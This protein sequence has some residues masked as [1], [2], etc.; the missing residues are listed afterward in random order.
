MAHQGEDIKF[1]LQGNNQINLDNSKFAV[2]IYF[3]CKCDSATAVTIK[4]T[5]TKDNAN[6]EGY[7]EQIKT[8]SGEG[9]NTWVGTIPHNITKTMQDGT[10]NM[11]VLLI[12]E[13]N[14]ERSIF[15]KKH[16]FD[17]ECSVSKDITL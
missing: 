12:N 15:D 5:T 1:T 2:S 8:E 7:F 14:Q 13:D 11:E 17:L 6:G 9:T 4:S 10:Y 16:V 3:H